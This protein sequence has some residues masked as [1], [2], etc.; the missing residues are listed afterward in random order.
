MAIPTPALRRWWRSPSYPPGAPPHQTACLLLRC[1]ATTAPCRQP[2]APAASTRVSAP[3]SCCES[4]SSPP[5]APRGVG[6]WAP[7]RRPCRSWWPRTP[8]GPPLRLA[9]RA[10]PP[11][12]SHATR[13]PRPPTPRRG[14][15]AQWTTA[16]WRRLIAN[17]GVPPGYSRFVTQHVTNGT[18][19]HLGRGVK[20]GVAFFEI[21]AN[22]APCGCLRHRTVELLTSKLLASH[23]GFATRAG[24]VSLAPYA[25]LNVSTA[26]G[27][28]IGAV[29][30]N[31]R[32]IKLAARA[33]ELL[34]MNQVHGDA[35]ADDVGD[36]TADGLLTARRA[37]AI[38]V[39]TADC[40]PILLEDRGSGRVAA[41]HAGWRGVVA[42][43]AGKAVQ[44]LVAA[45]AKVEQLRVALGP[46]IR[47]CCFQVSGDL[48][49]K[50]STAFGPEVV[51]GGASPRIDLVL[52]VH[53]ALERCG[54]APGQI[55][56]VPCCTSCDGRFFSHR[57]D[58]GMT[59]RQLSF[60]TCGATPL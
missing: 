14:L 9:S 15:E 44:R 10:A 3:T 39:R 54:L 46:A 48:P 41:V 32:R 47:A 23:H 18:I 57:R 34:L 56:V 19:P 29:A 53:I 36:A 20:R 51:L 24:G 25:S 5:C 1:A 2:R 27:D 21:L 22:R 58:A 30:E 11:R 12:R 55:D 26:V 35:I 33:D 8:P 17:E 4:L 7:S 49:E 37:V 31:L 60:I 16:A 50:F 42:D 6:C 28:D 52:A 38:G 45:G 40:L 13:P 59:G 43:I